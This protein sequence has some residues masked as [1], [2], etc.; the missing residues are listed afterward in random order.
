M[1]GYDIKG[2]SGMSVEF[3]HLRKPVV[4]WNHSNYSACNANEGREVELDCN[5]LTLLFQV[6]DMFTKLP[7]NASNSELPTVFKWRPLANT[8]VFWPTQR[9]CITYIWT[10]PLDNEICHEVS[11]TK[12]ELKVVAVKTGTHIN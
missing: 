5:S 6:L 3:K 7:G 1:L 8:L 2:K 4:R 12:K 9:C 10:L 11:Q